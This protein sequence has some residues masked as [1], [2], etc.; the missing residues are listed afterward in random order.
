MFGMALGVTRLPA[1]TRPL[2]L[3]HEG[4]SL[5][6][7]HA[8]CGGRVHVRHADVS[9]NS[10]GP[11][12][13]QPVDNVR[14]AGD[15]PRP[16]VD[17]RKSLGNVEDSPCQRPHRGLKIT[18]ATKNG[19]THRSNP[20][21][22]DEGQPES[23]W[24]RDGTA[25]TTGNRS[26]AGPGGQVRRGA[27]R[28]DPDRAARERHWATGAGPDRAAGS[29]ARN[30]RRPTR[31]GGDSSAARPAQHR[32]AC[33]SPYQ[34]ARVARQRGIRV[35][36]LHLIHEGA[37]LLFRAV[38]ATP[39]STPPAASRAAGRGLARRRGWQRDR[40]VRRRAQP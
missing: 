17:R 27:T 13:A 3:I 26:R 1:K 36:P 33:G 37:S 5:L 4:A 15:N 7:Q 14:S 11:R 38:P 16:A 8:C 20:G 30:A 21:R 10:C 2:H 32:A 19:K 29:A 28:V 24:T 39:S 9:P 22:H 35:R 34:V 23:S 18:H 40:D 25:A 6:L 12:C 31:A